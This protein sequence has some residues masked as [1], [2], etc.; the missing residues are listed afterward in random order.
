MKYNKKQKLV[1]SKKAKVYHGHIA[2]SGSWNSS[3]SKTPGSSSWLLFGAALLSK[4]DFRLQ[5]CK[6]D[7]EIKQVLHGIALW[8]SEVKLLIISIFLVLVATTKRIVYHCHKFAG[9]YET[10]ASKLAQNVWWKFDRELIMEYQHTGAQN[11]MCYQ[12]I[13]THQE[14]P[15][16]FWHWYRINKIAGWH[17]M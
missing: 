17:V 4:S 1:Q 14:C 8:H 2:Q 5:I 13:S 7:H 6:R 12:Q 10:S 16:T 15:M 3:S 9:L 11:L